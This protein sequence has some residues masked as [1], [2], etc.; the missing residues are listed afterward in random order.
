MIKELP[1]SYTGP[2]VSN[3]YQIEVYYKFEGILKFGKGTGLVLPVEI[4]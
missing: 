4:Y 2:C 3:I 1:P